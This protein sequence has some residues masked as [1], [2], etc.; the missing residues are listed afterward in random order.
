M[1]FPLTLMGVLAPHLCLMRLLPS[2]Q[3][4]CL[5]GHL[6]TYPSNR[7]KAYAKSRNPRTT[8]EIL[9]LCLA[10]YI[11]GESQSQ[12]FC[13]LGANAKFPNP[14]WR[15]VTRG[16]EKSEREN[17]VNSGHYILSARIKVSARKNKT[18]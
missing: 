12:Y 17:D 6:L 4:T 9:P 3:C 13:E 15:K 10:N 8:F 1:K 2:H 11:M 7:E 14:S 18:E 5:Q 16:G